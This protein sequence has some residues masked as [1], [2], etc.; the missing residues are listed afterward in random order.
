MTTKFT[1]DA[2]PSGRI[3]PKYP[4]VDEYVG[5]TPLVRLQ[6]LNPI[7]QTS[8]RQSWRVIIY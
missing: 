5:G 6:R 4:T 8:L 2:S 3:L 1:L 7:Y